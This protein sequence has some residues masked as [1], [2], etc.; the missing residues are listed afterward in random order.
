[1]TT[2][3]ISPT[4]AK[5]GLFALRKVKNGS[6]G[7]NNI[8][9]SGPEHF[10]LAILGLPSLPLYAIFFVVSGFWSYPLFT[11]KN[12]LTVSRPFLN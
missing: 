9:V 8:S 11:E 10:V 5:N 7:A 12:H 3:I 2:A 6:K 1:M 4:R